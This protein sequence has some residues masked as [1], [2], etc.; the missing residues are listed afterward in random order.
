MNDQL[1][2]YLDPVKNFWAGQ[3]K[4]NKKIFAAVLG[5][6]VVLAAVLSL[7][8]N[9]TQYSVL[10]DGLNSDEAKAVMT[11]LQKEDV[12]CKNDGNTIYI[13]KDKEDS[14]RME[15]SNEGYPKSAPNY[16]F[17]TKNVGAMTTD[18]EL[19][20]IN[21]Y[22][23]Q[24]RLQAV[25]RTLS[26]VDTAYV[27][28][29]IPTSGNYAWDDDKTAAAASV[30]VR[31][32]AGKTLSAKQVNGIKQ[33]VSK[34]VPGMKAENV[35]VID[36]SSMEELSGS[37]QDESQSQQITLSEFKMKIEKQ[38][39]DNIQDKIRSLLASTY[40]TSNISV[41]VKSKMDLDKKIQDIVTYTPS[42]SEGKGIVSQSTEEEEMTREGAS[43][44]GGVAGTT[45]N[46][47][48]TTT[49]PGVTVNGNIITTRDKKT[50]NYLVNH[51]EEQVQSDA[52]SLDD[53]SVA[54]VIRTDAMTAAKKAD[55][56]N[57]IAKAAAVDPDKVAVMAS[58]LP[59]QSAASEVMQTSVLPE[60]LQNP[61]ILAVGGI[62]LLLL[63]LLIVLLAAKHRKKKAQMLMAK[64]EPDA[65]AAAMPL[66]P[67]EEEAG[68]LGGAVLDATKESIEQ[69]RNAMD[70][71]DV[72][73]K[74]Q[75]TD[76][77]SNNPEIAAQLIRSW[78][79]GGDK[80]GG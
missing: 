8:M 34:S 6:I 53:L 80:H 57:L 18:E 9:R 72:E 46:S 3:S 64:L 59:E 49:Y 42:T 35:S 62:C 45:T 33:L 24:D 69:A 63:I 78:L 12:P 60:V 61:V 67:G 68:A 38:Y 1:K 52:A 26:P 30:A 20:I 74:K 13:A 32:K 58:A 28:I 47:D 77:S 55:L 79:K 65:E 41:S 43:S 56:T 15:L 21:Q 48:T 22:Q 66:Q 37:S 40:G 76:F 39:E 4:R 44:E 29:S 2:K 70:A 51:V 19:K 11:E 31:L 16:D 23:L 5:G 17:F 27:N 50:Y 14:V 75:L 54:V 71:K 10:Y 73:L 7:L 36:G 25:I